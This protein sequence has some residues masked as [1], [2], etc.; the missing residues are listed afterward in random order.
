STGTIQRLSWV[1]VSIDAGNR[2]TYEKIRRSKLWDKVIANLKVLANTKGPV[3]GANFVVTKE[4][5]TEIAQFCCLARTVGVSY[6]KIAANL[7]TEGLAYYDG[8]LDEI[9]DVMKEAKTY[10]TD[11]FKIAS[12]FERRLEDL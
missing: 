6:V 9:M 7:T 4:N 2:R 10:A 5:Y 12:V 11:T 1:R 3:V 8:I